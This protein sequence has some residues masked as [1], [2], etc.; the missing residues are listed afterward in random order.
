MSLVHSKILRQIVFYNM[1]GIT[2]SIFHM[3]YSKFK[4]L[5]ILKIE[6]IEENRIIKLESLNIV[7]HVVTHVIKYI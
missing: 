1:S 3:I 7:T 4:M 6:I 5:F 2:Y